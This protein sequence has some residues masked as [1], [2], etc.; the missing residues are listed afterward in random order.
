VLLTSSSPPQRVL[1]LK[2]LIVDA[3]PAYYRE[4]ERVVKEERGVETLVRWM[5][6]AREQQAYAL[7]GMVMEAL[8]RMCG[9]DWEAPLVQQVM[10]EVGR[11]RSA[12]SQSLRLEADKL[13]KRMVDV[14]LVQPPPK[15]EL[16]PPHRPLPLATLAAQI[17][18][19][20]VI[21][22]GGPAPQT[23]DVSAD[24]KASQSAEPPPAVLVPLHPPP[25]AVKAAVER[26]RGREGRRAQ[27]RQAVKVN[28]SAKF[29]AQ[30]EEERRRLDR[31]R[32]R[33]YQAGLGAAQQPPP[34]G[35]DG[36][37]RGGREYTP[38]VAPAPVSYGMGWAALSPV[39][40]LGAVTRQG[41]GGA[42][43]GSAAALET[44]LAAA[45]HILSQSR[46][47]EE[48]QQRQGQELQALQQ[49]RKLQDLA[50]ASAATAHSNGLHHTHP[51]HAAH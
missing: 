50:Q 4:V 12:L 29:R 39:A 51:P 5:K 37:H 6:E 38:H 32:D 19:Q 16:S 44:A 2:Q 3:P 34:D 41:S 25:S 10:E 33:E 46:A 40:P 9:K 13:G 47:M 24:G 43:V 1:L 7:L 26:Q 35:S 45:H 17:A 21:G 22:V 28:A 8:R 14:G 18:G 20:A 15:P 48:R 36:P 31:A 49:L 23:G 27:P 30:A 11:N 42:A